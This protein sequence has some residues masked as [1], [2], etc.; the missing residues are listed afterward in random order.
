VRIISIAKKAMHHV[1]SLLKTAQ[2]AKLPTNCAKQISHHLLSN[3]HREA[4][5]I[6]GR[7]SMT[8]VKH[9]YFETLD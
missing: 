1:D 4:I 5:K 3:R 9:L 6:S 7:K 2:Q 8:I